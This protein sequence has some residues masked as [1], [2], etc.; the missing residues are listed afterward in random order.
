MLNIRLQRVGKR[1]QAYFRIIIAEHTKKPKGGV[2]EILG[3]YDPHKKDL[4]VEKERIEYWMSKGA[5]IS[6]TVNNLL[7]NKKI[8]DKPK[9]ESWK[10]KPK[11][12]TAAPAPASAPAAAAPAPEA[13]PEASP[14]PAPEEKAPETPAEETSPAA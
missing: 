10:P 4:K 6:P 13:A 2:L 7:I 1:G 9:M 14:E 5:Q 11:E 3:S 8:W 12:A